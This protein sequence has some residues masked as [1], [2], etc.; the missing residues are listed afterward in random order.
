MAGDGDVTKVDEL[1]VLRT[2]HR[3][4]EGIV[5]G[6]VHDVT[7]LRSAGEPLD[8]E[9]VARRCDHI[10]SLRPQVEVGLVQLWLARL[11]MAE[12]DQ[13]ERSWRCRRPSGVGI[14]RSAL[15]RIPNLG[16]NHPAGRRRR[17]GRTTRR[18]GGVD[19]M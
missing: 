14:R 9:R 16:V 12:Y 1:L 8:R 5:L 2:H 7:G 4:D 19:E 13:W 17:V 15:C 11:A 6:L 18:A 3:D 10:A